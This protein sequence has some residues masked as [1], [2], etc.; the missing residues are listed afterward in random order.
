MVRLVRQPWRDAQEWHRI[1]L[2]HDQML[3]DLLSRVSDRHP[4]DVAMTTLDGRILTWGQLHG[5]AA[6]L[7]RRL[8][9]SGATDRVVVLCLPDGPELLVA[10]VACQAA[11]AI[12]APLSASAGEAEIHAVV[13]RTGAAVIITA[14]PQGHVTGVESIVLAPG[15]RTLWR[16]VADRPI[17]PQ[18]VA[19]DADQVSEIMFTSGTTGRPK[20]VMNTANT[21]LTGLRGF[22]AS[23]DLRESD[24]WGLV[25]PMSHNAGWLYTALPA[26]FSGARMAVIGRGNPEG[27]LDRLERSQVTCTF[28]VP[29]HIVDLLQAYRRYPGRWN[30]AL[31]YVITGAAPSSGETLSAVKAEWGATPISMYGMT[32]T[33]GNTFTRADDPI[34]VSGST[35]GRPCPGTSLRLRDLVTGTLYERSDGIGRVGEIVTRGPHV[36]VGYYDDEATTAEGFTTDGWFRTGDLGEWVGESVRV[37]GRLKDVIL[38][39]G[40]TISPADVEAAVASYPGIGEFVVVGLPDPRLGE[41]VCLAVVGDGPDVV[42]LRTH[43][44]LAGI[45]RHLVPDEVRTID[46]LPRTDLGKTQRNLV[47]ALLMQTR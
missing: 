14:A 10:Q 44:S 15:D 19:P 43:L 30:L 31:R 13:E 12:A 28:L 22:M 20:G 6:D 36:F 17:V 39:G 3:P 40:Q 7:A 38:R 16:A 27:M 25:A 2:W 35:V 32:E 26:L 37:V 45:G 23:F 21:K 29:T 4:D 41:R 1:G 11:G 24:V 42:Q 18:G 33:Q 8:V 5:S 46:A 9:A 34:E 47:Q